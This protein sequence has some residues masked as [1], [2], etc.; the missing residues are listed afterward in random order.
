MSA[1]GRWGEDRAWYEDGQPDHGDGPGSQQCPAQ[2][3]LRCDT[4][5]KHTMYTCIIGDTWILWK[6]EQLQINTHCRN[7]IYYWLKI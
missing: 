4:V 6:F 3:T 1:T 2:V 7:C 5:K